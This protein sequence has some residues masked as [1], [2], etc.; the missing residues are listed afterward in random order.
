MSKEIKFDRDAREELMQG[1]NTLA[2]TVKVTLGPKGRNVVLD[3]GFGS[4]DVTK[5]GVSVAEEIEV[6]DEFENIGVEFI[7]EAASNTNDVVGDGT[8]T[9]TV[10]TQAIVKEG[11][12][13]VAAGANPMALNRGLHKASEALVEELQT[14][15][16]SPVGDND[17]KDVASISAND[18]EIGAKIAE[19]IDEVGE[20]GVITVEE[21]QSFGLDIETVQGMRFDEGFI[22]PYMVTD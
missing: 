18:E 21:S 22:S 16:A 14:N 13:N 17:I 9:A 19:A 15:I 1:V 8:T 7:K 12:K 4:P 20:D 10:L 3:K 5:D 11:M 2:D 6:E